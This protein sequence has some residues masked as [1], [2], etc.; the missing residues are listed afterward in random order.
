MEK[1]LI[2]YKVKPEFKEAAELLFT[3][4][5][6]KAKDKDKIVETNSTTEY[7]FQELGVLDIWF[8]K[9]YEDKLE[10]NRWYKLRNG[11]LMYYLGASSNKLNPDICYGFVNGGKEWVD[12]G[13]FY[14]SPCS[15]RPATDK[16]VEEALKEY[17]YKKYG[18]N[19]FKCLH[20]C[21]GYPVSLIKPINFKF[22]DN[23]LRQ[24]EESCGCIFANGKWAEIVDDKLEINGITI[25]LT[26][27]QIKQ[28]VDKYNQQNK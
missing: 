16:E 26:P 3:N 7:Y 23:Y 14:V 17:A 2:G 19:S 13:D 27:E 11:N 9:V 5:F 21:D 10:V 28:I 18:D 15:V 6:P 22:R 24:E 12:R 1:K 4:E 20:N 8:D 25:E